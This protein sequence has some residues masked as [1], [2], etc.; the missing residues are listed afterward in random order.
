MRLLGKV[1]PSPFLTQSVT[2]IPSKRNQELNLPVD[3]RKK[4]DN[5]QDTEQDLSCL[6][7]GIR[8]NTC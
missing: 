1:V 2:R 6:K 5:P 8:V 4:L 7:L 3:K